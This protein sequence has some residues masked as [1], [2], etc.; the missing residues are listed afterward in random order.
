MIRKEVYVNDIILQELRRI[1]I[2]SKIL[3]E[4]DTKWPKPDKVGKQ[5]LEVL[6]DNKHISFST[7]KFGSFMDLKNSKDPSGLSVFHYL[8]Q[9]IK[10]LVFSIINMHFRLKPV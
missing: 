3:A 6:L 1:V 4:D 5:E 7:C 8:L 2:D 9:D 10:C